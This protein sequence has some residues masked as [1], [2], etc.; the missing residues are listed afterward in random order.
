MSVLFTKS[1]Q[2]KYWVQVHVDQF[3]KVHIQSVV[4]ICQEHLWIICQKHALFRNKWYELLTSLEGI[5]KMEQL[6]LERSMIL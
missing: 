1:K 6:N 3:D 5:K 2:V 4:N